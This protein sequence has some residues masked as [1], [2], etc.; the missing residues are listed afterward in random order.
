MDFEKK[1]R[2]TGYKIKHIFLKLTNQQWA[3][4]QWAAQQWAA[5]QWAAQQWPKCDL[6]FE[7]KNE[8]VRVRCNT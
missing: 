2:P 4:Q 3:A 5:Q 7:I 6:P 1:K 8:T